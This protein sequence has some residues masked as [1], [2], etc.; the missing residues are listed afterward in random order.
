M[1][2]RKVRAR[3]PKAKPVRQS[4]TVPGPLAAE[5]RRVAKQRNLTMSRAIVALAERGVRAELDARANLKATYRR[6]M[7]EQD[8]ARKEEAGKDLIRSIFGKNAIAED[9]LL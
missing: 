8:P 3:S 1:P 2:Q 5:V 4:V 6:F 9:P 7:K